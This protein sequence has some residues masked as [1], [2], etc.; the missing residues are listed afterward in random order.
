MKKD[1]WNSLCKQLC[2]SKALKELIKMTR[3][4]PRME[5]QITSQGK[6][7]NIRTIDRFFLG[8]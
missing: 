6:G 8:D 3:K 7:V 1:R 4:I 2:K 5:L